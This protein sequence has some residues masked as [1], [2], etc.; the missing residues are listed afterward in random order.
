MGSVCTHAQAQG[1]TCCHIPGHGTHDAGPVFH[2]NTLLNGKSYHGTGILRKQPALL[3]LCPALQ[4]WLQI[5]GNLCVQHT[6]NR[7][8]H[9]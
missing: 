7:R 2:L 4:G 1:R 9:N 6:G 5:H 8:N 3:L